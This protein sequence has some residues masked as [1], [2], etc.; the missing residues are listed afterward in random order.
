MERRPI[1]PQALATPDLLLEFTRSVCY[2]S[3]RSVSSGSGRQLEGMRTGLTA[4]FAAD[5]VATVEPLP[6]VPSVGAGRSVGWPLGDALPIGA[7]VRLKT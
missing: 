1:Q 7:G 3:V 2:L 6:T 4:V 5:G